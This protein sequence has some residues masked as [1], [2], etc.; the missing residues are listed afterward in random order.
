MNP[1][2]D[3]SGGDRLNKKDVTTV[4]SNLS[5]NLIK[6]ISITFVKRGFL[7]FRNTV[8]GVPVKIVDSTNES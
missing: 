8:T 4:N 5:V 3:S 7:I 2:F 6:F 1:V